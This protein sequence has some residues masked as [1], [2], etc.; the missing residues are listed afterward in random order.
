VERTK[1][2][3]V[4]PIEIGLHGNKKSKHVSIFPVLAQKRENILKIIL[5]YQ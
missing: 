2:I 5:D 4:A 3:K 1:A